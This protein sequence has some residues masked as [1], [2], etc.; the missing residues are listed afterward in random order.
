MSIAPIRSAAATGGTAIRAVDGQDHPFVLGRAAKGL[1]QF[2]FFALLASSALAGDWPQILG[3]QRDGHAVGE[4]LA[5]WDQ[6]EPQI[7]WQYPLGSGYAGCAVQGD[8][9][10]VAHRED[11]KEKLDCLSAD[12]GKLVWQAMLDAFYR[13]GIDPD[14][15]PRCVPVVTP[16]LVLLNTAD[17]R[18]AAFET[19][20]G[21]LRWD[22]PLRER[23]SADE[24]YFGAGS[25]PLVSGEVAIV[26][27][28]G[29]EDAGI[30]AVRLR[31]GTVAWTCYSGEASYA[32][33][34]H[35]AHDEV[36]RAVLVPMRLETV[37]V[38]AAAGRV[39]GRYPFGRRG[40]TV[41][42]ATPLARGTTAFLTASYNVGAALVDFRDPPTEKWT[43][44][45]A[46]SSQYPTPVRVGETIYGYHGR[47]DLGPGELRAVDWASGDIRWRI[48][49]MP[50]L[51]PIVVDGEILGQTVDGRLLRFT[52]SP[53][54]A[55]VMDE[56]S[57]PTGTYRALPALSRGTLY[58][59]STA[60][61]T[62]KLVALRVG[63]ELDE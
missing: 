30:V 52:A 10:Y 44:G 58:C 33:P 23:F 3:Q 19:N 16:D 15:G 57:L 53:D 61:Q 62:G 29:A 4:Q 43:A 60:D 27:V 38:D 25:T 49:S 1:L 63:K 28:G 54:T 20:T 24:G 22:V 34:I 32:S 37:L 13:P 6:Q 45:D 35:I 40:P 36:E 21:K 47:E 5:D 14:D 55:P 59:R 41:N 42:A 8:F 9:V 51:H 18:L 48:P 2:S 11:A 26:A 50:P 46:L 12:S 17:G 39:L 7:L 56:Y 31:D